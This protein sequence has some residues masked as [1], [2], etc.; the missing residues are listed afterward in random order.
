MKYVIRYFDGAYDAD[1]GW[2]VG[3]R[4]ATL[5]ET[6]ED[7]QKVIEESLFGTAEVLECT[8]VEEV[9]PYTPAEWE[10]GIS[11]LTAP[12]DVLLRLEATIRELAWRKEV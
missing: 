9:A 7:A 2:P 6:R 10:S 5:Y 3:R 11:G 8:G 12:K 4:E 1:G